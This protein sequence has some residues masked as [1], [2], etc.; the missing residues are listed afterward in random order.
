MVVVYAVGTALG[1]ALVGVCFM[2]L[3]TG[4]RKW[5]CLVCK[6]LCAASRH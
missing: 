6:G 3:D 5:D 4:S 2:V 1:R